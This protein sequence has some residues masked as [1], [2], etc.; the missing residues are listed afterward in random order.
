MN[1]K[2]N[3]PISYLN[4]HLVVHMNLYINI[5]MSN[6]VKIHMNITFDEHLYQMKIHIDID[7]NI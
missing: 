4:I 3:V 2:N 6:Q 7:V 5:L 1:I